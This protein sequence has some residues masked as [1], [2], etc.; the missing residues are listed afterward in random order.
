M[1]GDIERVSIWRETLRE[2]K[3][4]IVVLWPWV[5]GAVL[6]YAIAGL[7]TPTENP[8]LLKQH[9]DFYKLHPEMLKQGP[10]GV[11]FSFL[12]LAVAALSYYMF[13]ALYLR[14]VAKASPPPMSVGGYFF[15]LWKAVSAHF[16]AAAPVI[17]ITILLISAGTLK[18]LGGFITAIGVIV[19]I[20]AACYA[21]FLSL[22][23]SVVTPIAVFRRKPVI[24]KSWEITKDQG[25]RIFWNGAM[26]YLIMALAFLA[27]ILLYI[28]AYVVGKTASM[29]MLALIQGITAPILTLV[30]VIFSSTAYRVLL[31]E[32][33]Q[34]A[35]DKTI[36]LDLLRKSV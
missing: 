21:I 32:Q 31:R 14:D 23:L 1:T 15:W 13:T 29:F 3:K 8:E 33:K 19:I 26:L 18:N 9:P 4:A 36:S 25:W 5:A 17:I 22:R 20:V 12:S 35:E 28:A 30:T 2:T 34:I 24:R 11:F 6:I 16:L 10:V 27:L 7:L